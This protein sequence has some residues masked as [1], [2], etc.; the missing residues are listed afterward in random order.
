MHTTKKLL[1]AAAMTLVI[2]A[3]VLAADEAAAP[4]AAPAATAMASSRIA[5]VNIQEIMRDSTAAK[6]VREQLEA[7][8]KSYQ[9]EI[10]KKE[11]ALQKEDQE[12]AKQRT[13]LSKEAFEKKVSAFREK[14][15]ATQKEVASK[16]AAWDNAYENSLGQIQKTV[17]EIISDLAKQKGF[18]A[19]FPT[20]QMLYA[21]DSLDIS[22]E[23]LAKLNERLPSVDVKFEAP[24]ASSSD[25][26]SSSSKKK[27]KKE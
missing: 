20:S 21:D 17:T 4:A 11:E 23:V 9:S 25:S 12:L 18:V 3:P 22:K 7:K 16:K 10:G 15:A 14:A 6:S 13:T 24:S 8:Q 1:I 19:T 2:S 27:H 5:V 26:G